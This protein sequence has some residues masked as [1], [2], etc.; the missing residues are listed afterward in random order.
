MVTSIP[1]AR[2][3]ASGYASVKNIT[4]PF[5]T[6]CRILFGFVYDQNQGAAKFSEVCHN[7]KGQL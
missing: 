7:N 1:T 6:G 2:M 4:R 3:W 5:W